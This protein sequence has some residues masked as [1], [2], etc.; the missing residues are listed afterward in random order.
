MVLLC[1]QNG[2]LLSMARW[3]HF[4]PTGWA[5]SRGRFWTCLSYCCYRTGIHTEK[6]QSKSSEK[7]SDCRTDRSVNPRLRNRTWRIW[8]NAASVNNQYRIFRRKSQESWI[9]TQKIIKRPSTYVC[10]LHEEFTDDT[11]SFYTVSFWVWFG[12]NDSIKMP[13]V[14]K[15]G[16]DDENTED[17][18][19]RNRYRTLWR[20]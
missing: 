6:A 14:E 2:W 17:K 9:R 5:T 8:W 19:K 13:V 20:R 16:K 15:L 4:S 12:V 1:P 11:G 3:K 7:M 18:I 10:T